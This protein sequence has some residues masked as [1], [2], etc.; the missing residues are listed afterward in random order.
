MW[1][2]YNDNEKFN[3]KDLEKLFNGSKSEREYAFTYV[4]NKYANR[5]YSY[6]LRIAGNTQD[7]DDIFQET[8]TNFLNSKKDVNELTNLGSYLIKIARNIELNNKRTK[9]KY[10]LNIEEYNYLLQTDEKD[11]YEKKEEMDIIS[12]ALELLDF[13]YKEVF[14]LRQYHNMEYTEIAAITNESI[15]VLRNRYFRAKEKLKEILEP[16]LKEKIN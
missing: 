2:K 12:N 11:K 5:L 15:P 8:F 9:K 14:I 4:Y 1:Q 13:Q 6:C 10:S 16:I 7:A 3:P